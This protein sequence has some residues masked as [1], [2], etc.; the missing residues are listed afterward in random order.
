MSHT[1]FMSYSGLRSRM[2]ALE[3]L[4]N[5]LANINSPGFKKSSAFFSILKAGSEG[6]YSELAE[7]I[8]GPQV[9]TSTVTDFSVGTPYETGNPLDVALLGG[10]FFVVDTPQGRR[11]TRNGNFRLDENRQLVNVNGYPVL[12]SAGSNSGGQPIILPEG[13]VRISRSGQISVDGV[14]TATMKVVTFQRLHDLKPIGNSL[15]RAPDGAVE[16][17]PLQTTVQQKYLERANVNVME[18]IAEMI[19]L[20]R[21]FEMM[22]QVVRSFSKDIN[23]KLLHE[24]GKV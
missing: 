6:E 21:S 16:Y 10:G 8:K 18:S 13:E 23:Q 1:L 19:S 5:N 15:F 22:S 20:M 11:Y 3:V 12:G 7:A 2:R 9:Q 4:T 17:P 14:V 24:V